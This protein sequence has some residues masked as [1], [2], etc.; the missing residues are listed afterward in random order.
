MDEWRKGILTLYDVRDKDGNVVQEGYDGDHA[1]RTSRII[2]AAAEEVGLD[3]SYFR[4]LEV[5]ALLHDIGRRG[6]KPE[7]FSR[8]FSIA[9][10]NGLPVRIMDM[11]RLFPDMPD[12]EAA[13]RFTSMI[14]PYLQANGIEMTDEVVDHI[15]MRM[16][17]KERTHRVLAE[18]GPELGRLGVTVKPWMEKLMLYYYY[19]KELASESEDVRKMGMLLVACENFE[20]YNNMKRG[21]DYY[22]RKQEFLR[23]AFR[24]IERFRESGL[25]SDEVMGAL[26]RLTASGRLD[27]IIRESRGLPAD[28]ELPEDDVA[29]KGEL[30]AGPASPLRP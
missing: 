20:A 23:D 1:E 4:D 25:V 21:R 22:G 7:L 10:E 29:F 12:S 26:R 14:K 2:L 16:A 15:G 6:M 3:K 19:P 27:G 30:G 28:A 5:T 9:Q 13:A 17:Y 24:T 11:R 8:I 18:L